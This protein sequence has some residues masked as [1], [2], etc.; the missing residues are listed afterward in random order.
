MWRRRFDFSERWLKS[1]TSYAW[2]ADRG[3][4]HQ[5]Y[6]QDHRSETRTML[7]SRTLLRACKPNLRPVELHPRLFL[8]PNSYSNHKEQY[9]RMPRRS[10]RLINNH[11]LKIG[12]GFHHDT[13]PL[14]R[15][16]ARPQPPDANN[17]TGHASPR[18]FR[19]GNNL[20]KCPKSKRILFW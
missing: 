12:Q 20:N 13:Y 9:G 19:P 11:W 17:L 8:H 7:S 4:M 6:K 1:S 18:V 3:R 2:G 15:K 14:R 16:S 10:E 5:I